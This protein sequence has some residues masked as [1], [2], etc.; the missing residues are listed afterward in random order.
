MSL[1]RVEGE[2]TVVDRRVEVFAEIDP[3]TYLLRPHD[4]DMLDG[5][6]VAEW[7]ARQNANGDTPWD[8]AKDLDLIDGVTITL[9]VI[10]R[11]DDGSQKC[12]DRGEW[13]P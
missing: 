3:T 12:V 1:R 5:E 13:G 8:L 11:Y 2:R 6:S 7:I 9:Q 4:L 10:E